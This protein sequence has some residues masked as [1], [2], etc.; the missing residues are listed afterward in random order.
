MDRVV[1]G[2]CFLLVVLG[3]LLGLG[4]SAGESSG[5]SIRDA[6]E[7]LSFAGTAVTG[8]VAIIALTS[9]QSQFRHA[10]KFKSLK[11]LQ[12]ASVD[13]FYLV[14]YLDSVFQNNWSQV[15]SGVPDEQSKTNEAEARLKW[16]EALSG[17]SRAWGSAVVFLSQEERTN[18]VGSPDVF[19]TKAR[20]Y[21][22]TIVL[23]RIDSPPDGKL[24][25]VLSATGEVTSYAKELYKSTTE[26]IER[27]LVRHAVK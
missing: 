27:M 1:L 8:V 19:T 9:W 2:G 11:E 21:A 18:F 6:M 25:G 26:E 16:L 23:A 5:K 7:L 22:M 3:V 24:V 20:E 10:E 13:L 14:N 4:V 15:E 12:V 17:Y